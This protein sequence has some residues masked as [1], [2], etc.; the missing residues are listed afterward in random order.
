MPE[1]G[2]RVAVAIL[3]VAVAVAPWAPA[4][5]AAAGGERLSAEQVRTLAE[6]AASDPVALGRLR[7]VAEVDGRPVDLGRALDGAGDAELTARLRTLAS[8]RGATPPAAPAS[9]GEEARRILEGREFQPAPTFRPLRG[10]LRR[11]GEWLRPVGEP[12]GR[13][14]SRVAA[15]VPGRVA[16]AVVVVALSAL[17]SAALVRRRTRA[18]ESRAGGPPERRRRRG[19][20]GALE[21]EADAAEHAGELERAFRLR[22]R[23][24]LLRLDEAGVITDR[25]ALTTG[26]LTRHVPSPRLAGLASAFEEIA[27]GGREAGPDDLR[28]ARADWP[29][30]LQEVSR[31]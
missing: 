19:D 23:A 18:G 20:P 21:R 7:Q 29:R 24:G 1:G 11:L 25:P 14:W 15:N 12:L 5:S 2:G 16:L 8:G 9:P 17:V 10:A 31:G 27:Y 22:F 4:A 28:T 3:A 30:V 26:E 13:R 6:Q